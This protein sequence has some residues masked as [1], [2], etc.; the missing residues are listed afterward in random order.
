[1]DQAGEH[2]IFPLAVPGFV[3]QSPAMETKTAA[4]NLQVIRT[5]MERSAIYRR[6]LAPL[7]TFAGLTGIA[8]A[9][10]GC[11]F[12]IESVPGFVGYWIGVA[13]VGV[14]GSLLL[15]RRQS[16]R[17]AEPFWS[18]PT[19]RVAQAMTPSL[20][21]G[22]L[23]GVFAFLAWSKPSGAELPTGT[24]LDAGCIIWLPAVWAVLYGC[25][26]HAAGFFTPRGLRWFGWLFIAAG[27]V[28]FAWLLLGHRQDP[29]DTT[30]QGSHGLMG[31]LF[32]L[33]Q[34]VYGIYLYLTGEEQGSK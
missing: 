28:V 2:S 3:M 34:L 4:D 12:K 21:A 19:R 25:A 33:L 24:N 32:G 13:L 14:A 8:A 6:A 7:M 10:A 30:W 9:V 16:I 31:S 20:A 22:L 15:V 29:P 23:A 27:T 1:L 18:P 26:L 17:I 11:F 5:L